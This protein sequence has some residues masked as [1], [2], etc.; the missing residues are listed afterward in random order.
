VQGLVQYAVASGCVKRMIA[1]TKKENIGSIRVLEKAG[2][3][4][5]GA[6]QEEGVVEYGK[7]LRV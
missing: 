4:F 3:V 7:D 1:H 6:G 2:F 5:I